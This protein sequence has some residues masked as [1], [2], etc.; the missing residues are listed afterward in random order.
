MFSVESRN[1]TDLVIVQPVLI[2]LQVQKLRPHN[3]SPF[4]HCWSSSDPFLPKRSPSC[5]LTLTL[6][7]QELIS[8]F[9]SP[10]PKSLF[11]LHWQKVQ[12]LDLT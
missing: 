5:L 11:Q 3:S 2:S 1:F 6:S 4:N 9:D 12:F 7:H 10:C 8:L